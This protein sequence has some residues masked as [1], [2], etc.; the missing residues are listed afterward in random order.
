[1]RMMMM[2]MTTIVTVRE[3]LYWWCIVELMLWLLCGDLLCFTTRA[4]L[5]LLVCVCVCSVLQ[6]SWF[7]FLFWRLVD[8]LVE[9]AEGGTR[10]IVVTVHSGE[11]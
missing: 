11:F 1:M 6:F 9:P 2:L 3:E 7:L 10:R 5:T 4:V 8:V